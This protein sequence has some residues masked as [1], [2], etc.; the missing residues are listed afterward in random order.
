MSDPARR[1]CLKAMI[2]DTPPAIRWAKIWQYAH[3][4][5]EVRLLNKR[6]GGLLNIGYPNALVRFSFMENLFSEYR[7]KT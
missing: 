7:E 3:A 2:Q 6:N 5:H 1:Q 4:L